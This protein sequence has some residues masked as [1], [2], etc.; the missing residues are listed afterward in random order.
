[1]LIEQH[2]RNI[3]FAIQLYFV[4]KIV[5][6]YVSL[7]TLIVQNECTSN[8]CQNGGRCIDQYNGYLCQCS[9]GW[10]G[11]SCTNDVNECTQNPCQNGGTCEN[12]PG[13]YRLA[14]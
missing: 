3:K 13:S 14:I 11:A 7:D 4:V 12:T 1:M 8:P 2:I 5:T 6:V 10:T 9:T